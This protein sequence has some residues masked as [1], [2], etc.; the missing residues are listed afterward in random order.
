MA[1]SDQDGSEATRAAQIE[2]TL[3]ALNDLV[4]AGKVRYI[5]ASSGSA[6]RMAQAL[7]CSERRGWARFVSMQNHYNLMYREEEREMNPLCLDQGVA[8]IPWS[9]LA[10]G[11]FARKRTTAPDLQSTKRAETDEF[12]QKFYFHESDFAVAAAVDEVAKQR[13]VSPTQIACA[14][15]LQAPGVAAPIVGATKIPHLKELIA[16]VDMTLSAEEIAAV[17]APYQPHP[18]LGHEQPTGRKIGK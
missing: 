12:A 3:E 11:F 13:G 9:P 7:S 4:R 18:I 8:L 5:G 17:E 15:I 10:R 14:W 6:W 16:T 1:L 2:E